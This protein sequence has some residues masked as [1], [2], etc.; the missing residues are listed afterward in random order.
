MKERIAS[1][2]REESWW[3]DG[4]ASRIWLICSK[5]SR[6]LTIFTG[7]SCEVSTSESAHTEQVSNPGLG[8]LLSRKI[9]NIYSTFLIYKPSLII[10]QSKLFSVARRTKWPQKQNKFS[11]GFVGGEGDGIADP[12]AWKRGPPPEWVEMLS[13]WLVQPLQTFWSIP[14]SSGAVKICWAIISMGTQV[15]VSSSNRQSERGKVSLFDQ[16]FIF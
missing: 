9:Y 4:Q 16:I 15:S 8:K 5:V 11:N 13:I 7:L 6:I 14:S 10:G 1:S 12:C 2:H 3:S